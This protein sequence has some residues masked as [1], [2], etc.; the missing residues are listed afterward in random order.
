MIMIIIEKEVLPY[1]DK[2]N[3]TDHDNNRST[4]NT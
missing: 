1:Y 3:D 4:V 2:D